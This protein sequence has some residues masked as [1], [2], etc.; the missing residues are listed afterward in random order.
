[1]FLFCFLIYIYIYI[2]KLAEVVEGDPAAPFSIATTTR[3]WEGHYSVP[4]IAPL[5]LD[6]YLIMMSVKQRDIKYHFFLVCDMT[7]L[8]IEP[9]SSEPLANTNHYAYIYIYIYIYI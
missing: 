4:W 5:T 2:S 8:G 1:M 7:Q 6:Q 9:R 3:F